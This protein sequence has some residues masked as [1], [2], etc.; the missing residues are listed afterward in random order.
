MKG[1]TEMPISVII[2]LIFSLIIAAIVIILIIPLVTKTGESASCTG[3][4]RH[5]ASFL[6]NTI[7]VEIC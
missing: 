2:S 3:F 6:A 7:G 1:Q 5:L 4:L